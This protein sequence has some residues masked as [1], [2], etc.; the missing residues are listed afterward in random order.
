MDAI[1]LSQV[2]AGQELAEAHDAINRYC[3]GQHRF[4]FN[5]ARPAVRLHEPTFG[6][7]EI[8]AA[9][10][11]MLSTRVTHGDKVRAF[12]AAFREQGGFGHAVAC[13]SGSSANLLAIAALVSENRLKS[14]DEVIV[15]ALSWS[16]TVWPLIQH[17]LIPVLVDCDKDTLNIDPKEVEKAIGLKTKAIMPVHVFGNP[18]DMEALCGLCLDYNLILIED[19]CEALGATYGGKPV[20]TFG[21]VGTF[22]F[23][24]SH[25]VTTME[26]GIVVT[27][28]RSLDEVL[29]IQRAHGWIRDVEDKAKY[30]EAFPGFDPK[31]LFVDTGYNLRLTEP[32]AAMGAIQ[33][34]KLPGIVET[35]RR[36][37]EAYV[38]ALGGHEAF[39]IQ[40]HDVGSSV[41]GFNIVLQGLPRVALVKHLAEANIETRP[42]ICGNIAVQPGLRRHAHRVVGDLKNAT[43]VLHNGLSMGCHQ[44]VDDN[45]IAYVA[46]TIEAFVCGR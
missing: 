40:S 39:R 11:C 19:C 13:N 23:Y 30:I 5:P 31:F 33:V 37:H 2:T 38:K 28:D 26:G 32:Q 4:G 43:D 1:D 9:L 14:G 24:F 45:A 8:I 17:G 7:K 12:E 22:S 46:E 34:G 42:I 41:F 36:N 16:T 44:F 21:D 35:R 3:D 29:R 15:S 27:S 18:C 20:G 6:A 25:H 10:D